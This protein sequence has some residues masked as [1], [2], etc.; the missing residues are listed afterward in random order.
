MRRLASVVLVLLVVLAVVGTVVDRV[1]VART[2]DRLLAEAREQLELAP[3]ADVEIDGFPFLTQVVAGRL[4]EVRGTTPTL[5]LEGFELHDVRVALRGVAPE[6]PYPAETVEINAEVPAATLQSALRDA[7]DLPGDPLRVDVADGLVQLGVEV[8][9][10][11]LAVVL[12]PVLVDGA[13]GLELGEVSV[14][15]GSVP[16]DLVDVV[17]GLLGDV[18]ID[19]PGLPEGLVPTR[20][21]VGRDAV[22]LRLQG[23]DVELGEWVG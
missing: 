3:D 6:A 8:A 15:G 18:R 11:D 16:Q 4:A 21:E 22:E 9:G 13:I 1:A 2:E 14:G 10:L 7:A 5:L 23:S 17:G 12:D 19:I 20:L